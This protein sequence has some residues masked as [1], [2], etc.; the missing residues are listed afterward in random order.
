V[1]RQEWAEKVAL[2]KRSIEE[3]SINI[4]INVEKRN[5][6]NAIMSSK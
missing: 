4:G 6:A 3:S 2:L 1:R 5:Q